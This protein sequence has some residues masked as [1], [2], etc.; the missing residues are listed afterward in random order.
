MSI[1]NLFVERDRLYKEGTDTILQAMSNVLE[2]VLLALEED[3][4]SDLMWEDVQMVPED[5]V[6]ILIGIIKINEG[7]SI[8]I[9]TGET[10][11]ITEDNANAFQRILRVG[12]PIDM[13]ENSSVEDITEYFMQRKNK[14]Y[15]STEKETTGTASSVTEFNTEDLSEEQIQQIFRNIDK[16]KIH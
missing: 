7:E 4:G 5:N 12:I 14:N 13:V 1:D 15:K 9:D 11:S 8:T 16:D 6:I 2:G 10:I 3:A